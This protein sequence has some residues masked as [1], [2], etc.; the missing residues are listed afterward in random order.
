MALRSASLIGRSILLSSALV[1]GSLIMGC[2]ASASDAVPEAGSA[3]NSAAAAEPFA[4]KGAT[5][6]INPNSPAAAVRTF[7]SDLKENR[8]RE[9]LYLTN[10]R[11]A[12]EGLSDEELKEFAVDFAA[13]AKQVPASIEINGEIITGNEATVTAKLPNEDGKPEIQPLKLKKVGDAWVIQTVDEVAEARIKKEGKN[14]LRSLKIDSHQEDAKE[15][16]ERIAKAQLVYTMQ[17]GGK[18]GDVDALVAAE[19]LPEDIK[20]PASTGYVY[21]IHLLKEAS[22]YYATAE[23]AEYGK[24]GKNSY[25]LKPQEK[26]MPVVTGRDNRGK[27]L[28]L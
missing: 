21:H 17:S 12:I 18:F 10:L 24:T 23:P 20:T 19:L 11:P 26:G 7:Y 13:I 6:D 28:K 22:E 27:P 14:Y 1:G 2:G 16:M 4:P 25:I 5:I 8:I 15:M 9:A 3:T